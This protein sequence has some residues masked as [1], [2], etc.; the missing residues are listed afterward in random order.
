MDIWNRES[1][2]YKKEMMENN[3]KKFNDLLKPRIELFERFDKF[4]DNIKEDNKD[5][6]E[7]GMLRRMQ[8][9]TKL[10]AD[11]G[12]PESAEQAKSP[13]RPPYTRDGNWSQ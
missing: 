12:K 10:E 5:F 6:Y 4:P 7:A 2:K 3:G 9:V 1:F 11:Y 8:I 13:E